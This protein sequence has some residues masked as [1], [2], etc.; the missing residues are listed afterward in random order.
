MNIVHVVHVF[1][2]YPNIVSG[3]PLCPPDKRDAKLI[4]NSFANGDLMEFLH[5]V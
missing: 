3:T 5:S 1:R 4:E 2:I